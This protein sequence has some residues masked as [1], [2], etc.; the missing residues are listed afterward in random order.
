MIVKGFLI[1][2]KCIRY[3]HR[4]FSEQHPGKRINQFPFEN[5]FTIKDLLCVICRRKAEGKPE[6]EGRLVT[7][8][9]WLPTTFNMKTELPE[10]VSYFQNREKE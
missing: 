4:E 7:Q 9:R 3:I 10:F 5:V 8:P 6:K 1:A 2:S